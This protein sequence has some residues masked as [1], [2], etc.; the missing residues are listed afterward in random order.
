MS[1]VALGDGIRLL[2]GCLFD[3][4]N[5]R[6][7]A[8]EIGDIAA[9][10]SKVCRFAGHIHQF[11]SV[12]Q[13]AVN[14]SRIVPAEHAFTALM[15]DT[16]EAFTNDLPTPLKFAIPVFKELEV[17][18]ESAMAERFGFAYPL[19]EPVKLAD[20]QMLAIEKHYLKRDQSAWS[21]LEGIEYEH[22][23]QIVDLSPM[24]ASRAERLFLERYADLASGT[25]T[26]RAETTGSV[27]EADGGP[28]PEGQT[29]ESS[30]ND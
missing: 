17:S 23:K 14:A 21:V 22:L 8:V 12:A 20:L 19:P 16:A 27:G 2:S 5:P 13:H 28:V 1:A 11:Y 4:N 18:I 15:H 30:R 3:Y 25:P 9:A 24:T 26:R 6:S 7:S 29:P 10:L